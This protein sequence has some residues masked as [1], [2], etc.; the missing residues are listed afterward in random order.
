MRILFLGAGAIGGYFGGRMA[1]SGA[2]VTF[3]VR[4][5][6]ISQ[7]A[8]GL[9][10][11]SPAGNAEVNVRTITAADPTEPFDLIVLTCK[12]FGL[13]GALDAISHQ[14]RDS[15]VVVPLLN[16]FRHLKHI[17]ARFPDAVVWGGVAQIPITL[18]PDG[19]IRHLGTHQ[20]LIIGPRHGQAASQSKAKEFVA[21]AEKGGIDAKFSQNIEQDMWDKWIFLTTLAAGTCLTR[22][23][24]G[25]ILKADQGEA[26]LLGLLNECTEVA[27]K[28]GFRP[29]ADRMAEYKGLLA[30]QSSNVTASMLRDMQ[31][32]FPIEA[33]HIVG[34]MVHRGRLWG[35]PTPRLNTAWTCLQCYENSRKA[36]VQ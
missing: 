33:D 27:T 30:D 28:E 11:E 36:S 26:L 12:A 20:G 25:E 32:G 29:D 15:T 1:K 4:E 8:D 18:L 22:S 16:G 17:E 10:I 34:D 9:R 19:T 35:I 14:V 21:T 5:P 6:R 23:N 7:L 24:V 3:L 13:E 31:Q 2:D